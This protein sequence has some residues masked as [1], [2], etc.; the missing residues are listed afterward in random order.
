MTVKCAQRVFVNRRNIHDGLDLIG[1]RGN[2]T[3]KRHDRF[4]GN[5]VPLKSSVCPLFPVQLAGVFC[6]GSFEPGKAMSKKARLEAL[7]RLKEVKEGA[8]K[9]VDQVEVPFS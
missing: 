8:V 4:G 6:S 9:R 2:V 1:S 3:R 5:R 7:K